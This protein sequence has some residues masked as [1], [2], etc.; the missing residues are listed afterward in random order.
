MDWESTLQLINLQFLLKVCEEICSEIVESVVTGLA[1][2][3]VT[4][5]ID[6]MVKR[7]AVYKTVYMCAHW[8]FVA[9]I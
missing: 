6:D 7:C 8:S 1:K 3:T 4:T 9:A 5:C 2:E